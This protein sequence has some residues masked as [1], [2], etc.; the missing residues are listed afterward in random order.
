MPTYRKATMTS[1]C[2][3]SN[4]SS[5]AA[6]EKLSKR[7]KNSLRLLY[8]S[9]A[10]LLLSSN[11]QS[12]EA[13]SSFTVPTSRSI[14]VQPSS[15]LFSIREDGVSSKTQSEE[16]ANALSEVEAALKFNYEEETPTAED[17]LAQLLEESKQR[18]T[19]ISRLRFQ[20]QELKDSLKENE[21]QKVTLEKQY[22][23]LERE[24]K[25]QNSQELKNALKELEQTRKTAEKELKEANRIASQERDMLQ[26]QIQTLEKELQ[27]TDAKMKQAQ[28]DS[29]IKSNQEMQ[30][31]MKQQDKLQQE[32]KALNKQLTQVQKALDDVAKGRQR[33]FK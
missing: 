23:N 21:E 27:E 31:L 25:S 5:S 7:K 10:V 8:L 28:I 6:G 17:E 18:E 3:S 33:C 26:N 1:S 22:K 19:Y 9:L 2:I 16:V 11:L 24:S 14:Y 12:S 4:V 29:E 15:A 13:F 30:T 32:I 20:L